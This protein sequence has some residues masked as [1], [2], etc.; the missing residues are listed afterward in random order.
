MYAGVPTS[1][2]A[3]LTRDRHCIGTPAICLQRKQVICHEWHAFCSGG[4]VRV[5]LTYLLPIRSDAPQ[6]GELFGYLRWL[7]AYVAVI[8]VDG[9][10]AEVFE[11]HARR[12]TAGVLHMRPDARFSGMLNQKV[13]GVLTGGRRA[14]HSLVIIADDDVRYDERGLN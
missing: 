9:S 1:A 2:T 10:P 3:L 6:S 12:L 14:T 7:S 5:P 13:A 8:I 4:R 11:N